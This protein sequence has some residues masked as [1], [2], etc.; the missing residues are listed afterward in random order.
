MVRFTRPPGAI[1]E[2][3]RASGFSFV[4]S[5]YNIWKRVALG[6]KVKKNI[7]RR[8]V[9]VPENFFRFSSVITFQSSFSYGSSALKSFVVRIVI[10][11]EFFSWA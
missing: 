3:E 2:S 10:V 11:L 1:S 9:K 6:A 5:S 7:W 8:S 4:D